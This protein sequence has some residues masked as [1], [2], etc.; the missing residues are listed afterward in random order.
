MLTYIIVRRSMAA[1]TRIG[2]GFPL[3]RRVPVTWVGY[4]SGP[5]LLGALMVLGRSSAGAVAPLPSASHA[6]AALLQQPP[7][8]G[9]RPEAPEDAAV[10]EEDTLIDASGAAPGTARENPRENSP[11]PLSLSWVRP[12]KKHRGHE[13]GGGRAAV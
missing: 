3:S 11:P 8:L 10:T 5:I 13:G 2:T 7:G 6:L 1:M 4:A 9:R 12:Y